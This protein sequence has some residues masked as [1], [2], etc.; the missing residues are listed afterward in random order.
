[1]D[2]KSKLLRQEVIDYLGYVAMIG[3]ESRQIE[4][5]LKAQD[6]IINDNVSVVS[7]D[8]LIKCGVKEELADK[9]VG[10]YAY[11]NHLNKAFIT[12]K[13]C[14]DT[15]SLNGFVNDTI[16]KYEYVIENE[17]KT[18]HDDVKRKK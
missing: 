9:F 6:D 16:E 15:A 7:K 8:V 18:P 11:N 14:M 2:E 3:F 13:D 10:K 1:M 17:Y 4:C 12:W 5:L